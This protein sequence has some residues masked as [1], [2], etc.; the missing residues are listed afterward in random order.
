MSKKKK[1]LLKFR[2]FLNKFIKMGDE[3]IQMR[4]PVEKISKP[5]EENIRNKIKQTGV[6]AEIRKATKEDIDSIL[7]MYDRAW[8]S[9]TMPFQPIPRSRLLILLKDPNYEILIV[10]IDSVDS[11]FAIIYITGE[12][13]EIGV[14]GVLGVVPEGQRKGL[15]TILGVACWDYFKEKKVKELRCRV[16]LDNKASY[17][18]MRRLGFEEFRETDTY[19]YIYTI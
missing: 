17:I 9:T 18:F 3:Y 6:N 13:K 4:L 15:G 12:E 14:I 8:H 1:F 11:A 2:K 5:F 19:K 16:Y 10:K 7:F